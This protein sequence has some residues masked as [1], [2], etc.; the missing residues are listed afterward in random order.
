MDAA[1]QAA[2]TKLKALRERKD[3]KIKPTPLLRSTFV[4]LDGAER[5][6]KARYYQVQMIL[7]LLAMKRFVV[8]DD[9]GLG[10]TFEVIAALTYL[11]A[12]D[13][14]RKVIIL[15]RKNSVLQWAKEFRKFTL[16]DGGE[17]NVIVSKGTP[18]HRA[19]AYK[20]FNVSQGP[21][22]MVVGYRSMVRDLEHV[23]D[24]E[25]YVLVCDEATVFK[26]PGTQVHQVVRHLGH[27][28]DRV[29]GLTATLIKNNLI[30]GFGIYQVIVPGLFRHSRTSFMKDYCI[31]RMQRVRGNRQVPVIVGYRERDI[32][33]FKDKIDPYYLGRPKHQVASELPVLTVRDIE[34]GMTKFQ[35]TKYNEALEGLLVK[36][37]GEEKETDRLTAIIYCQQIA[38]HPALIGFEDSDSE[39]MNALMDLLEEDGEFHGEKVIIFTR[40]RTLVDWAVPRMKKKGIGVVRVTGSEDED[41]RQEAMDAFQDPNSDVQVIWI[42]MAGG[43]AINLQMAKAIV[44]YDSPWS[45]GDYLQIL[46]RMIRIGSI[47]DRCYALH[48]I[49]K[50]TVDERVASVRK[51]KMQ[52]V[53]AILGKR[54]KG[55]DDYDPERVYEETSDIQEIFDGL[56]SDARGKK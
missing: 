30:E 31:I 6:L 9:T 27:Q 43:D 17:I 51:K 15:A 2:H 14:D 36:G 34:V 53:E 44:F 8:G 25:G 7:H 32:E 10:K 13:P 11:W 4:A 33:R 3:L 46:G 48:L 28:A 19:K 18:K 20:Q 22:A 38:N 55:D 16:C 29:W 26:N 52:L 47:H 54:L 1:L 42:T 49:A 12:R 41:Q 56:K 5:P 40:F 23:Q 45:A 21:T 37:D 24:W 50:Q 35:N 39:K